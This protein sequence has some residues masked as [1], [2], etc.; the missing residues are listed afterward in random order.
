MYDFWFLM[1]DFRF[2]MYDFRFPMYGFFSL[3]RELS[4]GKG[5]ILFALAFWVAV[6][7]PV[8]VH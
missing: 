8:F 1:Y 6:S 2:P 5:E 4:T 7:N 3:I